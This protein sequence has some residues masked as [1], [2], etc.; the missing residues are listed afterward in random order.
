MKVTS[1]DEISHFCTLGFGDLDL[2]CLINKG[3]LQE[4]VCLDALGWHPSGWRGRALLSPT[5][6][7]P[8]IIVHMETRCLNVP[9]ALVLRSP[10]CDIFGHPI[11]FI[12]GLSMG[13]TLGFQHSLKPKCH[14]I[15]HLLWSSPWA[16]D[17][18]L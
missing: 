8:L 13:I 5:C 17:P 4:S 10:L 3:D 7:L 6:S 11:L 9:R 2:I 15:R 14:S 1:W 18:Q 12:S 16:R